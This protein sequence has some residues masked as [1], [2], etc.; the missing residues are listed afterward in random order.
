MYVL[1]IIYATDIYL[2]PQVPIFISIVPVQ[3]VALPGTTG[4]IQRESPK[5]H[6][7][8]W[9]KHFINFNFTNCAS[10]LPRSSEWSLCWYVLYEHMNACTRD[11][12][13]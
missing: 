12:A 4:M 10:Y 11:H 7:L 9:D 2:P 13:C 1:P 8:Y 5:A 3:H 6:T